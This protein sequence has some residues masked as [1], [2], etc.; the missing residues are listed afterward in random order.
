MGRQDIQWDT[1]NKDSD[2]RT[3]QAR[4]LSQSPKKHPTPLAFEVQAGTEK[5]ETD[6]DLDAKS[7]KVGPRDVG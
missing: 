4:G 1:G 5:F 3:I 6:G 7:A 2:L